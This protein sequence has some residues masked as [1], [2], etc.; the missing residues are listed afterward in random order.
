MIPV[1]QKRKMNP[2][3]MKVI[4]VSVLV[5]VVLAFVAGVITVANIVIQEE[6]QFE[7][8]PAVEEVE[9]PKEVKVQIK[10]QQAPKMQSQSL[11]MRPVANIAVANVNVTLPDMADSFTVSEGLGGI[12]GGGSLLGGT[13]GSIGMGVSNVSVFGLKTRAERILFVIDTNRQMVTDKKGGLNSYK[14]IKDEITDMVGNLSAGTLFNVML[15]DRN[16]TMLFKSQLVSA[17]ADTHQQLIR[18]IAPINSDANNPGLEGVSGA[19]RPALPTLADDPVNDA[20]P[21]SFRGNDTAFI[22]QTALE[23]GVDAIF[24]ITGY[25]Q[26]F[27]AVRRRMTEKEQQA[28]DKKISDSKYIKQLAAHKLEIPQMEQRI[29]AE[30]TKQNAARAKKGM[31]PRVLD[32]RH[33]V[34]TASLELGMEWKVRHPGHTPNPAVDPKDV[35]KYFKQLNRVLYEDRDKPIPSLNVVL[36]LAEDELFS[37][38]AEKQLKDY[39]RFYR[40]KHRIIRGEKEI[41]SARSS[42]NTRN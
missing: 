37:K 5:H 16:K 32:R 1:E 23:Q 8:P 35:A 19:S 7:E 40:G 38:Q 24:F 11:T 36:F 41:K 6:A 12:G 42:K 30:L 14:V 17:G 39:V 4:V 31:P 27:E 29:K 34:Y 3:L 15:H 33:G 26:G 10:Q 2:M 22:T 13:S 20:L 28:W 25:H 18:W 9:P 21:I